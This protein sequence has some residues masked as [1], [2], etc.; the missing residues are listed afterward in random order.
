ME[1]IQ[2]MATK[3]IPEIRHLSYENRLQALGMS[4]LKAR[5]IRLDLIYTYKILHGVDNVD[6]VKYFKLNI[7]NTR[8]NVYKLEFKT[9]TT[10]TLSRKNL[11]QSSLRSCS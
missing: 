4:T 5:R 9:H 11:E 8:N 10:N 7:N 2:A 3:L 6:Y 1:K